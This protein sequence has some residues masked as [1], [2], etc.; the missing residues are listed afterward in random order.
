MP[1][2][3]VV[4]RP[5]S[6]TENFFRSRTDNEFYKNFQ[7]TSTYSQDLSL[8]LVL[9][10]KA[11]RKTILDYHI[12]ACNV[13]KDRS[14][15]HCVYRPI[16]QARLSDVMIFKDALYLQDDTINEQLM[17]EVDDIEFVL[18]ENLP[19][20][21]LVLIDKYNL[22]IV[23]EHTIADGVVGN[24]FHEIF[25]ENLA[26]VDDPSNADEFI[27]K[28]GIHEE[29][30]NSIDL[31]S[32]LFDFEKDRDLLKNN[33]PPP[34][35]G[36]LADPD[37]D[38]SDN[39]PGY[40][41][42]VI[43]QEFPQKWPGRFPSTRDFS[44]SFKLINFTPHQTK[45]ILAKCKEE[46]V[47][48]TSYLEIVE[49]LTLQPIFGDNHHSTHKI[50]IAL[51][52]HYDPEIADDVYKPMLKNKS[53]K[54]LGT[55]AHFG[56]TENFPP[57]YEFSWDLVRKINE[58]L[59]K[60]TKNKKI[61]N[62][63]KPFKQVAH[64]IDDNAEFFETQLGKP[65]ADAMKISNLGYINT[66]VYEIEGKEPWKITNMIFSQSM[67]PSAS[68]FMLNVIS[69]PIGGLNLVLSYVDSSFR[70]SQF[71]NFDEFIIKL[72]EN[73]LKYAS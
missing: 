47:T 26:Y 56:L 3:H 42:K 9:I 69:T 4:S 10:Y 34:I 13:F 73:I 18:Y 46:R 65:K 22:S 70:D 62:F 43:P 51:R 41:D 55:L 23:L 7:V 59:I 40:F 60:A 54:I 15:G 61:L 36:F 14:I 39:D 49:V 37:E 24:Y 29:S 12:L 6:L 19:L 32:L 72:K 16:T 38:Y 5:L 28:Y 20:F 44:I 8:R 64:S 67:S 27:Q 33:L 25:L 68:E 35:D 50:A 2:P 17:K 30:E 58:D 66:P 63:S 57:I 52:R 21:K 31:N 53:Y 11:L 45:A 1:T 48:I 71:E